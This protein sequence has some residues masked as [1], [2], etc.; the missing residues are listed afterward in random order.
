MPVVGGSAVPA[1]CLGEVLRH[2]FAFVVH[3]PWP[4]LR[5]NHGLYY[6]FGRVGL[7]EGDEVLRIDFVL[8]GRSTGSVS[9]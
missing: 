9:A 1:G 7:F 4:T 8:G 5:R 3:V 2:S 6:H